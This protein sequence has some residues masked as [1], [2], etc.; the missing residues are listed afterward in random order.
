MNDTEISS[1]LEALLHRLGLIGES[2]QVD[3]AAS[4]SLNHT[5]TLTASRAL[6][7][8]EGL[9]LLER[10]EQRRGPG[11]LL[12]TGQ[13]SARSSPGYSPGCGRTPQVAGRREEAVM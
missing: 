1:S 6:T 11:R 5:D 8:L 7:H 9:G 13:G 10:S 4:R 2:A 12:H 3:N